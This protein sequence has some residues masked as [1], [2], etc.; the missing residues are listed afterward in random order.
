MR[1]RAD[2]VFISSVLFTIA[3]LRLIRP[4]LW[5]AFSGSDK[6]ALAKLDVGFQMEAQTAHYLGVACVAIILIGLIVVWTGYVKRARSAWLVMF[7]IAWAWAFPIFVRP[8][9]PLTMSLT[10]PEWIF[11]AIYEPG[12][13][14]IWAG[15][16]LT[17]SL[18]AIALV[19]PIKS[20]FLV[21]ERPATTH[22]PWPKLI[23]GAAVTVLLIVIALF[24]WI[25]A[26]VYEIPREQLN[27]WQ[28]LPLPPPPANP[29]KAQQLAEGD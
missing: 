5:Y 27:W 11:N 17:F 1:I 14:R 10:L 25:H 2:S 29:C 16:V 19:L 13:P 28:Q 9:F 18:M 22:R 6:T 8:L 26:Q 20:F 23:G 21:R 7:V 12:P 15:F 4:A 3:L 24:V